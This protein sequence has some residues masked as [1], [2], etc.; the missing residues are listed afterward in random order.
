MRRSTFLLLAITLLTACISSGP[1]TQPNERE[2][3]LLTADYQWLETLRKSQPLPPA[4]ATRKQ[5]IEAQLTN[6][7]K[8]EPVYAT[9][10]DKL[11]EY[12]DRTHDVRASQLMAREKIVVG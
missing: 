7:Q 11:R 1:P 4:T 5:Q 3:T 12:Y 10:M 2:W 9:L 6:L 8:I